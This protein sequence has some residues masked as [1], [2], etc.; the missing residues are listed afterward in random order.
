MIAFPEI[1]VSFDLASYIFVW[2]VCISEIKQS[3]DFLETFLGK[4]IVIFAYISE[5]IVELK[6]PGILMEIIFLKKG[7]EPATGLF[8]VALLS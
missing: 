7:H 3:S 4:L 6:A 5:V 1:S 8:S 2:M